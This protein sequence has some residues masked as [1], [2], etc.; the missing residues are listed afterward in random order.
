MLRRIALACLLIAVCAP[1]A[2]A[3]QMVR[4]AFGESLEPYVMADDR[5]IEV[6]IIRAAFQARGYQ[7]SPEYFSQPR[8]PMA[9]EKNE[10]DAVAT[11]GQ[12]S[13]VK[14][15]F[16]DIYISYEDEAITLSERHLSLK[17]PRELGRYRVLAF[18]HARQYL[19]TA[20]AD[21][22]N[23]NPRY[24]ETADQLNQARLLHRGLVDVVIADKRIFQW[25]SRRQEQQFKEKARPVDEHRLFAPTTYRLACR[26]PQL[27]AAFNQGLKD[28]L[29]SGQYQKILDQYR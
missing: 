21:M 27:C 1:V 3:G 24:S 6:D 15:A 8:L 13:G 7:I 25:M 4:V 12:Q 5:G 16:S 26:S 19:G 2:T 22:A 11:L 18:A 28:I 9:L 29:A 17:D 23:S 14:A 20:F 10:I